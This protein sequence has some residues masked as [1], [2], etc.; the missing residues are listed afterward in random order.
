MTEA[1]HPANNSAPAKAE[2]ENELPALMVEW[3]VAYDAEQKQAPVSALTHA[4]FRI[5]DLPKENTGAVRKGISGR[6]RR[7]SPV[8]RPTLSTFCWRAPPMA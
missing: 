3:L 1:S 6:G 4:P 7:T 2:A 5:G 8:T